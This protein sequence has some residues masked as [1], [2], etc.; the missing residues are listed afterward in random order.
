MPTNCSGVNFWRMKQF[1][2]CMSRKGIQ[3]A[4]YGYQLD[5]NTVGDWEVKFLKDKSVRGSVYKMLRYCDIAIV[6]YVHI[7]KIIALLRMFRSKE[8]VVKD[9]TLGPK[10]LFAEI[11]DLVMDTPEYNPAFKYGWFPG[12]ENQK[13]VIEHLK[14]SHGIINSTDYLKK[15]HKKFNKNSFTVPNCIDFKLWDLKPSEHKRLRIGWIGGGNHENDLFVMQSVV[16]E[17]TKKYPDVDFY[18][19]S[20]APKYLRNMNHGRVR[21]DKKWVPINYYPKHVASYGFD[22]GVAPLEVNKF[23]HGKSNLKW[24]EYSAL[25]IP[26]VASRIEPFKCIQDG[27]TGFLAS[28]TKEWIEKISALIEN[29]ELRRR[30]GHNAHNEVKKNFNLETVT[31]RYIS[32]LRS[33]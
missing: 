14:L 31:D 20:G 26:T 6:G 23:N 27:K 21:C 18:F 11:D 17:I 16:P 32:I 7:E 24:L 29:S 33:V 8:P 1:F 3:T 22:I 15:E 13:A 19:C 12:N 10:T 4:M 25:K 9:S 5:N 30:M 2:D 28:N